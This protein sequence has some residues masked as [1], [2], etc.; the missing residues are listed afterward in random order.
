MNKKKQ[1]ISFEKYFFLKKYKIALKFKKKFCYP[2][3]FN[4]LKYIGQSYFVLNVFNL[5]IKVN[6]IFFIIQKNIHL[7]RSERF[8]LN[9]VSI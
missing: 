9:K 8:F 2:S 7:K 4:F 3:S 1:F 6:I 5:I